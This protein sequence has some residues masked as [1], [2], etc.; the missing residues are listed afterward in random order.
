M[1]SVVDFSAVATVDRVTVG[2][3]L[4]VVKARACPWK[5]F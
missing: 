4:A 5:T 1:V 3:Y 2:V